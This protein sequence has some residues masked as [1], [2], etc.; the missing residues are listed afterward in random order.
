MAALLAISRCFSPFMEAK[1]RWLVPLLS[2][3]FPLFEGIRHNILLFD[4]FKN[5][6]DMFGFFI[7]GLINQRLTKINLERSSKRALSVRKRT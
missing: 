2:T 7:S 1:P 3:S 4:K 5:T 6:H